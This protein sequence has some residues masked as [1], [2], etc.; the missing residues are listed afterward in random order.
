MAPSSPFVLRWGI[1]STGWIAERVVS[2][3]LINYFL[4]NVEVRDV[5]DVVH[6]VTAVGSRSVEK[7]QKFITEYVEGDKSVKAYGTYEEVYADKNVDAIYIGTPHTYHYVNALD[8]IRAKKHVLCEKPVTVNSAEL[9]SLIAEAKKQGVFFMEALW[10]RF[11]PLTL[12]LKKLAED[13]TLG[14]PVVVHADFSNDFGISSMYTL[15]IRI[16]STWLKHCQGLPKTHRMMDPALGGG[17]ILDLGPY[18][19]VWA[20]I[21]LYEHPSNK[22]TKP[23]N[24]TATM[25]KLPATGVDC[26]TSYTVTFAPNPATGST[27]AA[28]AVLSCSMNV[29]SHS[30]GV[31]IRYE[32]GTIIIAAPVPCPR[33]FTVQY[34]APGKPGVVAR[35]ETRKFDYVGSGW[36]FQADEVARCVRDGKL[37]S[38]LWGHDKSILEMEVFDEVRRQGNY[39]LPDGVEKVL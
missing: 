38:A 22:S 35:E 31:T 3:S 11:Q 5:H 24:I 18:P 10:T 39:K 23:S 30:P 12:E 4:N 21:A 34:F 6:K 17:A 25:Y 28:Q 27:L 2:V 1:I 36:H 16:D 26:N 37:E 7:A 9:R 15:C 8:A 20:T 29:A 19:L 14:A 33:S 32:K 13:G